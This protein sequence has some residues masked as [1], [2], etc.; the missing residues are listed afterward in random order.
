M[1]GMV[2]SLNFLIEKNLIITRPGPRVNRLSLSS[3]GRRVAAAHSPA[4]GRA[5]RK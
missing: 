1:T 5:A 3:E 4:Q 2:V